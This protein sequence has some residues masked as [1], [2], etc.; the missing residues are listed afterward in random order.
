MK[1]M[2]AGTT[3][4]VSILLIIVLLAL[5]GTSVYAGSAFR[6]RSV[7]NEENLELLADAETININW[8]RL[9]VL[10]EDTCHVE[11]VEGVS[12]DGVYC[13]PLGC[14]QCGG[15]GCG[16]LDESLIFRDPERELPAGAGTSSYCCLSAFDSSTAVCGDLG[17]E[18]PCL[19]PE[20]TAR[21]PVAPTDGRDAIHGTTTTDGATTD[22]TDGRV[23]G[24]RDRP[25]HPRRKHDG[26]TGAIAAASASG[27]VR[28]CALFP[29]AIT[30][31]ED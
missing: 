23:G 2:T 28:S 17:V 11:G 25:A 14:G 22:G 19:I 24:A 15:T 26:D 5:R 31:R 7:Q 4:I 29:Q 3:G 6:G 13:C 9:Q 1:T 16:S 30:E 20:G 18:P 8:R 10:A 12:G 21:P 27:V